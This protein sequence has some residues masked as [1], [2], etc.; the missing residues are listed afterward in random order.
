MSWQVKV[1]GCFGSV[2]I[3]FAGHPADEERAREA[4]MAAKASGASRD[5]FEKEIVWHVHR[6][7]TA[8]EMLQ[9]LISKNVATLLELW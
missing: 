6:N 1:P 3:V 7:V 2:D 4:I 8:R 9:Q 5:D